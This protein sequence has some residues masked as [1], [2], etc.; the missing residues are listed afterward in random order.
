MRLVSLDLKRTEWWFCVRVFFLLHVH[1]KYQEKRFGL[2]THT[3]LPMENG[4]LCPEWCCC[5]RFSSKSSIFFQNAWGNDFTRKN[6]RK[7]TEAAHSILNDIG[8][9]FF[10]FIE[11][12]TLYLYVFEGTETFTWLHMRIS[13]TRRTFKHKHYN[14]FSNLLSKYTENHLVIHFFFFFV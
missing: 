6:F 9:R 2:W 11:F 3:V 8:F 14:V 10:Y 1:D 13:Q 12:Q 4:V 7:S 5:K